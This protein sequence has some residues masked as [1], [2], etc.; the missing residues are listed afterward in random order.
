MAWMNQE[1][2]KLLVEGTKKVLNKYKIKATFKVRNHS[3]IVVNI[4]SGTLDFIKNYNETVKEG[5]RVATNYLR[6]NPYWYHYHFS[7][8]CKDFMSM[9]FD[10]LNTGNHDNSDIQT[11]YFDVGWYVEVNIGNFQKPYIVVG[12]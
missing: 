9:L 11:D 12:K 8:E 6:V 7:G 2:K 10:A 1:R 5:G 4:K 3:T